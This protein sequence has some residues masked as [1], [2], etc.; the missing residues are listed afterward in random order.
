MIS[1]PRFRK[2]T[3]PKHSHLQLPSTGKRVVTNHLILHID[4]T[5]L[6]RSKKELSLTHS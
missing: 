4:T 5:D 6:V 2:R 3:E 1:R